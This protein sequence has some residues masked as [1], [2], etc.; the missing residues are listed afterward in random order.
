VSFQKREKRI[1]QKKYEKTNAKDHAKT[2]TK[3]DHPPAP[4]K[5]PYQDRLKKPP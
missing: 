2:L 4:W 5:N 3:M 1:S